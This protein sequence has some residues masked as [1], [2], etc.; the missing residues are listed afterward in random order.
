M[1]RVGQ[2]LG[3]VLD[4]LVRTARP[5]VIAVACAGRRRAGLRARR[6]GLACGSTA[7]ARRTREHHRDSYC[8]C[9]HTVLPRKDDRPE[10]IPGTRDT[11]PNSQESGVRSQGVGSP[12]PREEQVPFALRRVDRGAKHETAADAGRILMYKVPGL[13]RCDYLED[14]T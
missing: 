5:L 1:P 9:S 10:T 12:L 6:L 14:G 2:R 13:N 11:T 3:P 4:H 8:F 7:N